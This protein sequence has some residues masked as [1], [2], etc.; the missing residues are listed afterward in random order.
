MTSQAYAGRNSMLCRTRYTICVLNC[1][2]VPFS[3]QRH[4]YLRKAYQSDVSIITILKHKCINKIPRRLGTKF[5]FLSRLSFPNCCYY[6]GEGDIFGAIVLHLQLASER[7]HKT[8]FHGRLCA[9]T[10]AVAFYWGR[11]GV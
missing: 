11:E 6:I 8:N 1:P 2:I 10:P 3:G 5:K 9:L 7:S 4:I